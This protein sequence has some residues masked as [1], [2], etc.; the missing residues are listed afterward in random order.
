[1]TTSPDTSRPAFGFTELVALIAAVMALNALAID[2]MLPALGTIGDELGAGSDN[3]RQLVIV[4]YV[5][6]NGVAQLF[7]GPVTDRFGR[8]RVLLIAFAAYMIGCLLSIVAETFT[9]LLAARCFQG[10][11]TAAA[12]VAAIAV[13]RDL[14]SGRRMAEVMSLAVTVFMAAPILAP[15]FGQAVLFAAPWRG[16]FVALLLYGVVIAAWVFFR[17]PETQSVRDRS[18]FDLGKVLGA[19]RAFAT[20]RISMGYTLASALCFGALFGYIT[21]SEQI[22]LET[23]N[24]GALFPLFFALVAAALGAASLLNARMVNRIGMRRITHSALLVFVICNTFHLVIATTIGENLP[25]FIGFMM[26]SFFCIGLIG[27]NS[28]ALAMEPMGSIAGLAAGI[29]G[30]AGTTVAGV[31]GGV[32]G[33]FYDGTTA[34]I[35]LGFCVL[36]AL[37]FLLV[38]WTEK[39]VLFH[40]Q[41]DEAT[42][43]A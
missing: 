40:S 25:L 38:L 39:G 34:P 33:Q 30:F 24:L 16:I 4:V 43:P 41:H 7:F 9:L 13:V 2:M 15:S 26:A 32:V 14:T 6:A 5:V 18:K 23:F 12:R 28:T 37:A 42:P 11:A 19:Y 1:M 22:F 21:S 17:L 20:N 27:A 31:I 10:V 35:V 8:R 3:A 29:N 36:G